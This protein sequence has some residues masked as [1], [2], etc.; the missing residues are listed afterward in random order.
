MRRLAE[1]LDRMP[2]KELA[3]HEW[4]GEDGSACALGVAGIDYGMRQL[5]T[6]RGMGPDI[7]AR[8]F[9]IAQCMA[10]EIVYINDD[11]GEVDEEPEARWKRVRAW[12]ED[13]LQTGKKGET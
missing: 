7:A 1:A 6:T 4:V 5:F 8:L 11:A 10:A 9:G 3:A 2:A 13:Q 12:V